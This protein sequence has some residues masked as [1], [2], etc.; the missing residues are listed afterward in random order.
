MALTMLTIF[1]GPLTVFR[2]Q[3][4]IAFRMKQVGHAIPITRVVIDYK[5]QSFID[6]LAFTISPSKGSNGEAEISSRAERGESRRRR[7]V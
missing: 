2:L 6:G 5:H 1:A 4:R 3:D 7:L